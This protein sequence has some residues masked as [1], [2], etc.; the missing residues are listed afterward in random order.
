[1]TE[2]AAIAE[3]VWRR[4][5]DVLW[6]RSLDA[7]IFLPAGLE[8]PLT[9]TATGPEIWDLLAEPRTLDALVTVLADV[10]HA[11]PAVVRTDIE[12][13]LAQLVDVGALE[14]VGL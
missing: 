1:M 4:R 13:V 8:E 5:P 9:L 10:H 12:P 6:R 3:T 14:P 2:P 7:V 11:D